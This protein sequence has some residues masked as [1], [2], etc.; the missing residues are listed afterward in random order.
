M[1]KIGETKPIQ[2]TIPTSAEG[3]AMFD[4][5][6]G[7]LALVFRHDRAVGTTQ[8]GNQLLA[9]TRGWI[10]IEHPAVS[11]NVTAIK[12]ISRRRRGKGA[13]VHSDGEKPDL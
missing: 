4:L 10:S 3:L 2:L 8:R 9:T 5:Q 13:G 11:I 7:R 6:D 12:R 1:Q